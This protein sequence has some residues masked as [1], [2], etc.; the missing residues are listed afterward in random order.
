VDKP[1]PTQTLSERRIPRLSKLMALALQFNGLIRE[2]RRMDMTEIARLAMVTQPRIT[3]VINLLHPAPDVQ[4]EILYLPLVLAG[5]D[6]IHEKQ[7]RLIC[8]EPSFARLGRLC[9]IL[10]RSRM[11]PTA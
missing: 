11:E 6:L 1:P 9:E 7:M 8:Q 5:R 3:Q 4:E 2:R 10:K